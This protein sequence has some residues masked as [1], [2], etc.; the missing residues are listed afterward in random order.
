MTK[1]AETERRFFISVTSWC[2]AKSVSLCEQGKVCLLPHDVDV[3]G[4]EGHAPSLML[5]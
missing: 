3:G 1:E 2:F 5:R 4:R